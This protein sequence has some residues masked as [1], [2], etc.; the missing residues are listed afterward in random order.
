MEKIMR[1]NI[2]KQ[3]FTLAEVLMVIGLLGV[4]AAVTVPNLSRTSNT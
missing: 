4:V 3:A 2:F 1:S